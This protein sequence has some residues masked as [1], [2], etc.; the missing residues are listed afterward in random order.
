MTTQ[1]LIQRRQEYEK[2][3]EIFVLSEFEQSLL[4]N[5]SYSKNKT[6]YEYLKSHNQV[7]IHGL[8][9]QLLDLYSWEKAKE[10][11]VQLEN[12]KFVEEIQK[13]VCPQDCYFDPLRCLNN[14]HD[15]NLKS[16]MKK[17]LHDQAQGFLN[18]FEY[19][20]NADSYTAD[21]PVYDDEGLANI[22]IDAL[23]VHDVRNCKPGAEWEL[24]K[25]SNIIEALLESSHI[26]L[27]TQRKKMFD[28]FLQQRPGLNLP[29]LAAMGFGPFCSQVGKYCNY[30]GESKV[31]D[32]DEKWSSTFFWQYKH[33]KDDVCLGVGLHENKFSVPFYDPEWR[34][35]YPCNTGLCHEK[36][37]CEICTQVHLLMQEDSS[38]HESEHLEQYNVD[39]VL[40][41]VQCSEHFV[42]HPSNF[43]ENQDIQI[44]VYNYLDMDLDTEARERVQWKRV[45][46]P[47]RRKG[48]LQE[49]LKLSGLKRIC[50]Q[51]RRDVN[52]HIRNHH[53]LHSQCKICDI[54]SKTL[55]DEHFWEKTCPECKM[56]FPNIEKREMRRHVKGHDMDFTCA[57]CDKGFRRP[58]YLKQH[59]EDVHVCQEVWIC[60]ICKK[61]YKQERNFKMHYR[62]R[63]SDLVQCFKCPICNKEFLYNFS[64]KR[65]L[66][67]KHGKRHTWVQ[68]IKSIDELQRNPFKCSECCK[69]FK[70]QFTLNRHSR[71]VHGELRKFKCDVCSQY[72]ARKEF[73]KRHMLAKHVASV[74][75]CHIC[76]KSFNRKDNL[77]KHAKSYH[78]E[79]F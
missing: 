35:C 32:S 6:D 47:P 68:N 5:H 62:L 55:I 10:N 21:A 49:T 3:R 34:I 2:L 74:F 41:N 69:D 40:T 50:A 54:R 22:D 79:N 63:H 9:C 42:D 73:L 7:V 57:S 36:C 46:N 37:P 38:K 60:S 77:R 56:Y 44:D 1:R 59:V 51:C 30:F 27:E 16:L 66:E 75:K 25:L 65:H 48:N 23:N 76:E 29:R 78:S 67:L 13:A 26:S 52:D 24:N 14:E 33:G 58:K 17:E 8:G 15:G 28:V 72:F 4:Q 19:E 11:L 39:C 20:N 43:I 64:L 53:I 61:S 70:E 18:F 71:E 45:N 12:N 31:I